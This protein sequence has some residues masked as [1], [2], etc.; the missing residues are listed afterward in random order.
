MGDHDYARQHQLDAN[1]DNVAQVRNVL[2]RVDGDVDIADARNHNHH[3]NN[4]GIIANQQ[5]QEL[6]HPE[7]N[8]QILMVDGVAAVLPDVDF[9]P[10]DV[11]ADVE[12]QR[13]QNNI[14]HQ[15]LYRA[16]NGNRNRRNHIQPL[17]NAARAH[18]WQVVGLPSRHYI[19]DFNVQCPHCNATKFPDELFNC[20]VQGAVRLPPALPFPDD[21]RELFTSN[22]AEAKNFRKLIRVYNNLFSFV[23]MS[24]NIVDPPGRGP[25]CFRICGQI[26]HRYGALF[27]DDNAQA[28]FSQI[29]LIEAAQAL[30]NRMANP[31]AADCNRN[32]MATIQTVL[33]QVSPWVRQYL[34]MKEVEEREQIRAAEENRPTS[35]V[36]MIMRSGNDNRRG[37][38]PVNNE[39]AAVFVGDDG[40]P[41]TT[42]D[43]VV[44]P[45]DQ[46]LRKIDY[47][48]QL[49]DPLTYPLLFPHGDLGWNTQMAYN[50]DN[51]ILNRPR[52]DRVSMKEFYQHRIAVRPEFSALHHAGKLF[53][54]YL[55]DSYTKIEGDRLHWYRTNQATIRADRYRGLHDYLNDQAEAR[56][57]RVGRVT[58]LPST[59]AGSPRNMHQLYLDAMAVVAVFGKPDLFVTMTCNPKWREITEN[60]LPGQTASDRPDLVSRVFSAK[61]KAL[62]NDI[63][64]KG[65]FG[66]GKVSVHV[67]E[68]QKRGLPHAHMLITLED[69]DKIR[70]PEDI[71][72]LICAE[73]PDINE[74]PELYETI[75]ATMIH[76]PCGAINP[77]S[78]C[79]EDGHCSKEYPKEF[80]DETIMA[81]NG[82][83]IYKRR[84]DGRT[85]TVRNME[86]DNRWVVPYNPWASKKY[87][88][89]INV[90]ACTS[91]KAI[92]YLFK[93]IYKGHDQARIE[94]VEEIE[95][96]EIKQFIDARYVSA[97]EAAW[98]IFGYNLHDSTHTVIRLDLHLPNEQMVYFREGDEANALERA[99]RKNT[100][101]TAWFELNRTDPGAHDKL[102]TDIPYHYVF[103]ARTKKWKIRRRN[104]KL[105]SRMYNA[106]VREG[107]RFYLRVLL[108]HV[109]GATSFEELRTFDGVLHPS[110]REACIARGLLQDDNLWI[111]TMENVAQYGTASKIR[112]VFCMI[113]IH[114]EVNNP[115]EIWERFHLDMMH[116]FLRNHQEAIAQNMVLQRIER[117]LQQFGKHLADFGL[118]MLEE[119]LPEDDDLNLDEMR[120]QANL[121]RPQL[122]A[123]QQT[124]CQAVINAVVN[125]DSA[126]PNVFF[127][128]GPGGTGKTFTYNFLIR[129]LL[130]M[131]KKIATCAWTGIAAILLDKGKT[132]HSLF[133][134]PVPILDNSTCNVTA[135]S[136]HARYLRRRDLFVIDEAS[137]I[138]KFAF[139]AIDLMLRDICNSNVP[140]A[141][142]VILLG[143]DFRQT[144]PIVRRG[145]A[146]QIIESC[147]K[148]SRLWHHVQIHYLRRNMRAAEGE[149]EFANFLL[150]L[151]GA[152]L[153]IKP[154]DP[155]QGCIEVPNHCVVPSQADLIN[156]IFGNLDV[157]FSKRAIL[158]PTNLDSFQINDGVLERLP[159]ET[160]TY[161]SFDSVISDDQD[162]IDRYP[163]EFLH[164]LTPSG[165]PR[166][167]LNVK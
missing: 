75:K 1:V 37:N 2:R 141:G 72:S 19:G 129:E 155:Y 78:P 149:Q 154:D 88:C 24:A 21:L 14:Q 56:Q 87:N 122:N 125:N 20:C 11:Q 52:R 117:H 138:P 139:E 136:A 98:R 96:D 84:E 151:G 38:A 80:S 150:R 27:P 59:F 107:E 30:N 112:K 48:S 100:K 25:P 143:G 110:F 135:N 158:T 62:K 47:T 128:D 103:D 44:Y 85:V 131:N 64:T 45:R 93:Y 79:M 153:P 90:E 111:T 16:N 156:S 116:D 58:I 124:V 86:L 126:H 76:G 7:N 10:V 54:Q 49:N 5:R 120:Q 83:P 146:A 68:F 22:S 89:H 99:D 147:L 119:A 101:L 12:N 161:F 91:I 104:V 4:V 39:V 40:A 106:S 163:Q 41:P 57:A 74:D 162:E 108:L 164:S 81:N 9:E 145:G 114:G 6:A 77:N 26:C 152:Q 115:P 28:S 23:S 113:L 132:M 92:Q 148:R 32:T 66:K 165:M 51:Q 140:F 118:P 71:D 127:L 53:Q 160:T 82:Y 159:G 97:P 43:V 70:S 65:I 167:R 69:G 35:E 95:H 109:A 102:Y 31:S 46:P 67:I 50:L 73:I 130:G 29:Y 166:H 134:L 157:D 33:H 42:R 144:L 34:N 121:L 61:L 36:R 17:L 133:K 123:D 13:G 94:I 137:M 60:L 18:I 105:V 3:P 63:L 55:V 142:K 15:R 8:N